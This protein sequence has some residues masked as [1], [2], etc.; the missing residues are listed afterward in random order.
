MERCM[1]MCV[2]DAWRGNSYLPCR[3]RVSNEGTGS[4]PGDCESRLSRRL[5]PG[6]RV[7][8]CHSWTTFPSS[9]LHVLEFCSLYVK[10]LTWR[11]LTLVN[12]CEPWDIRRVDPLWQPSDRDLCEGQCCKHNLGWEKPLR[13]YTSDTTRHQQEWAVDGVA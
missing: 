12:Q 9:K 4:W 13:W 5:S 11:Y 10:Q 1:T 6:G 7:E 3:T 8:V 2:D